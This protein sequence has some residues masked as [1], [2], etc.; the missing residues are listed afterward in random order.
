LLKYIQNAFCPYDGSG[1]YE[2][3][4]LRVRA[5]RGTPGRESWLG[6]DRVE[7]GPHWAV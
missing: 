3:T 2:R 7:R 1:K 4:Y 5:G 6:R